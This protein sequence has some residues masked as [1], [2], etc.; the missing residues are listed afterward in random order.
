MA[1]WTL[2]RA[3][4]F[5]IKSRLWNYEMNAIDEYLVKT[6]NFSDGSTHTATGVVTLAGAGMHVS[7]A[8]TADSA[9]ITISSGK[10]LTI[11]SG[12][13]ITTISGSTST[14]AGA[15]TVTSTWAFSGA[16]KATF[17]GSTAWDITAGTS[18]V[19][20][21]AVISVF[22]AVSIDAGGAFTSSDPTVTGSWDGV[23]TFS[24]SSQ[25]DFNTSATLNIF[26]TAATI[27]PGAKVTVD[28]SGGSVAEILFSGANAKLNINNGQFIAQGASSVAITGTSTLS[29]FGTVAITLGSSTTTTDASTRTRS[30]PETLNG[31]NATTSYRQVFPSNA[32]Q[33]LTVEHGD[34][35]YCPSGVNADI[36]YTLAQPSPIKALRAKFKRKLSGTETGDIWI[37]THTGPTNIV[38]FNVGNTTEAGAEVEYNVAA[39]R[40]EPLLWSGNVGGTSTPGQ[41][42]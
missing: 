12:G 19:R 3:L 8:F 32:T 2:L 4:G 41:P 27:K 29:V 18:Y 6:P 17:A 20:A 11:A 40:W 42:T 13:T 36:T 37:A 31:N 23:W 21:G 10:T 33:T 28:G 14:F 25:T 1:N 24:S 26:T 7:G 30:G 38:R 9:A 16:G 39:S 5:A 15:A 22:G 34:T 35:F